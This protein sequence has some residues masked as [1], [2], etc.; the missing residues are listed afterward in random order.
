[1][2]VGALTHS[3]WQVMD[4]DTEGVDENAK[5]TW[6]PTITI[7]ILDHHA[8]NFSSLLNIFLYHFSGMRTFGRSA[9]RSTSRTTPSSGTPDLSPTTVQCLDLLK[10]KRPDFALTH[11]EHNPKCLDL[12][13]V[14]RYLVTCHR[15]RDLSFAVVE[16]CRCFKVQKYV[17]ELM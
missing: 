11:T 2:A 13:K 5:Q 6:S 14:E 10:V 8:D 15:L 17:L 16:I 3:L 9:G 12:L 1:M 4:L 7:F